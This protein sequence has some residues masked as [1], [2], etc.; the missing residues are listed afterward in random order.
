MGTDST[1]QP[2]NTEQGG[3][4]LLLSNAT[5]LGGQEERMTKMELETPP[6]HCSTP[7]L[8]SRAVLTTCH[9]HGLRKCNL[10]ILEHVV[11]VSIDLLP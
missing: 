1:R 6:S 2:L 4:D 9:T 11:H 3:T 7:H 8:V 5:W 10:S